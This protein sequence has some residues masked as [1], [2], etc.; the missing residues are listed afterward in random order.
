MKV[1]ANILDEIISKIEAKDLMK[2]KH[3]IEDGI[4][5]PKGLLKSIKPPL[6]GFWYDIP[7]KKELR[8]Y[9]CSIKPDGIFTLL[10][11]DNNGVC[12]YVYPRNR[13]M[14][15]IGTSTMKN[16]LC[17][18]EL[19]SKN[20]FNEEV[21]PFIILFDILDIKEKNL[22]VRVNLLEN[23]V[24]TIEI[25]KKCFLKEIKVKSYLPLRSISRL[26]TSKIPSDGIIF[27][28]KYGN[29]TNKDNCF[30]WKP[31]PT[32][33]VGFEE[34]QKQYVLFFYDK[35]K[36]RRIYYNIRT[37]KKVVNKYLATNLYT[38]CN[39]D[40]E[41]LFPNGDRP[42]FFLAEIFNDLD[43]FNTTEVYFRIKRIRSDKK[44]PDDILNASNLIELLSCPIQL[45]KILGQRSKYSQNIGVRRNYKLN[46]WSTFVSNSKSDI[47]RKYCKGNLLDLGSGKGSDAKLYYGLNLK[48]V[49]LTEPDDFQYASLCDYTR[50][51]QGDTSKN[52][53]VHVKK[54]DMTDKKLPEKL[55]IKFDTVVLSNSVQFLFNS[56]SGVTNIQ[57][58]MKPG[59]KLIIIFMDGNE[60]NTGYYN[61]GEVICDIGENEY[62]EYNNENS[63]FDNDVNDNKQSI[64]SDNPD[65]TSAGIYYL[66]VDNKFDGYNTSSKPN[67]VDIKLPWSTTSVIE[68]IVYFDTLKEHL[69]NRGFSLITVGNLSDYYSGDIKMKEH[70]KNLNKVYKCAVFNYGIKTRIKFNLLYDY[71]EYGL[72]NIL[73]FL[74]YSDIQ[75]LSI[76]SRKMR[77]NCADYFR[78]NTNERNKILDS[79]RIQEIEQ[80]E[81]NWS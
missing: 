74:T 22:E 72:F 2:P 36:G 65:T 59:G 70:I 54:V 6:H 3:L 8:E 66:L 75:N 55:K 13:R 53:S 20:R 48:K 56:I 12:Y 34:Q 28:K 18:G 39:K 64:T 24:K 10:Y 16:F 29:P 80:E 11:I 4:K 43:C 35:K 52:T 62:Y 69:Y 67:Y 5:I 51:L 37:N 27:T 71:W 15:R 46:Q 30:R 68:P 76:T 60:L 77:D 19:M 40:S 79:I 50:M 73:S 21:Q 14:F 1:I 78:K 31:V 81:F 7:S 45:N 33:T 63:M 57:S 25:D 17:N 26:S 9:V 23:L 42:P 41:D 44:Y 61:D 47:F 32:V 38:L 49:Y 58:V